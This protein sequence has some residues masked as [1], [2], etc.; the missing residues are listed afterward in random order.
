[1]DQILRTF[2]SEDEKQ[3]TGKSK[4]ICGT[5]LLGCGQMHMQSTSHCVCLSSN[6][7]TNPP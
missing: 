1:M 7:R 6:L 3:Q 4:D 5:T 2:Q